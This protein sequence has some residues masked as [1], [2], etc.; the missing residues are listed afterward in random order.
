[1]FPV[2]EKREEDMTITATLAHEIMGN[3][4][5]KR[6]YL[7][8]GAVIVLWIVMY[9]MAENLHPGGWR[10]VYTWR[11]FWYFTAPIFIFLVVALLSRRAEEH[12]KKDWRQTTQ[13]LRHTLV[14]HLQAADSRENAL[15]AIGWTPDMVAESPHIIEELETA[16][17]QHALARERIESA[18][19]RLRDLEKQGGVD[20]EVDQMIDQL[21]ISE[22]PAGPV[23]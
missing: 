14:Q 20:L 8:M 11:W 5:A 10:D 22:Q 6:A 19:Q 1:L 3:K 2:R 4:Y 21:D 12:W 16:L 7:S 9:A 17:H 13:T 18:V 15:A 23:T